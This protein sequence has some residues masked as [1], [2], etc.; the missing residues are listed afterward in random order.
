M[1]CSPVKLTLALMAAAVLA[2]CLG[3]C[4]SESADPL[5]TIDPIAAPP[6]AE[7]AQP[8]EPAVPPAPAAAPMPEGTEP[9]RNPPPPQ[10]VVHAEPPADEPADAPPPAEPVAEP[11][12]TVVTG[13]ITLVSHVPAASEVPYTECLTFIK[14][15][16]DAVDGGEYAEKELLAV[17][18]GMRDSKLQD[19]ARFKPGQ[20]H[21]LTI[22]PMADHPDL[23]RVMQADDTDEYSL[24]PY[25]VVE[26]AAL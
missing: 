20:R 1:K 24:T 16:V 6:P 18:W 14:Y 8:A 13:E 11:S 7:E 17:F 23:S 22:E 19:A 9:D 25:W 21:R 4:P 12:G 10:A 26:Y 5:T 2:A 15:T 3:G